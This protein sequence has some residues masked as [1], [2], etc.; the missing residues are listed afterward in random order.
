M[1]AAE[2]DTSAFK[3][4]S[5]TT[6]IRPARVVAPRNFQ[7]PPLIALRT[8]EPRIPGLY[9]GDKT[10]RTF[11][12]PNEAARPQTA[13]SST[14]DSPW[15]QEYQ[16]SLK[17]HMENH[18]LQADIPLPASTTPRSCLP[19]LTPAYSAGQPTEFE[20]YES[21][22]LLTGDHAN[23]A[24]DLLQSSV[25]HNVQGHIPS[26]SELS[27]DQNLMDPRNLFQQQQGSATQVPIAGLSASP[28]FETGLY[29]MMQGQ[30]Q[31][32]PSSQAQLW[33]RPPPIDLMYPIDTSALAMEELES[34]AAWSMG[35]A[36]S[37]MAPELLSTWTTDFDLDMI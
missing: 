26:G 16:R 25:E 4:P 7:D 27:D 21:A 9:D 37:D 11:E 3:T 18:E 23:T 22:N 35:H 5:N 20:V 19:E 10:K 30:F 28:A 33:M 36:Y 15:L 6:G 24:E 32:D 34:G 14:K 17:E 29:G 2:R 31:A 8:R 13:Q 12:S 1:L